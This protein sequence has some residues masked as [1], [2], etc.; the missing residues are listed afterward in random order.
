MD[1]RSIID[2]FRKIAPEAALIVMS[3]YSKDEIWTA[4]PDTASLHFIQKP[5][6]VDVLHQKIKTLMNAQK[7]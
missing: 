6:N 3:V 5:I 7:D 2:R 4:I 1:S